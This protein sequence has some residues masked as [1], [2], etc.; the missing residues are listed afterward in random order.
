MSVYTKR[1]VCGSCLGIN[2]IPV[3]NLDSV[4]LA[5]DFPSKKELK[6]EKLY[7]LKIKFCVDCFLLQ[8]DSIVDS[9]F[10]FK[11]YRYL[12]SIGLT[13]HFTNV[14]E[15]YRDKFNLNEKSNVLD[16]G[17]NDGVLVKPLQDLS[18]NTSGIDPSIN[19]T[20]IARKNGCK[21]IITDF[22]SA[23]NAVKYFT[24]ESFDLI[25][26]NNCFA[27]I[28][29]IHT[30]ISGVKK[31][32]KPDGVFVIEVH[33]V[34]NLIK[35]LQYDN[36]YHE[37]IYYYSL[38]SLKN[39]LEDHDMYIVDYDEIPVHAGSIRVYFKN[40][41]SKDTKSPEKVLKKLDQEESS[42]LCNL[43]FYQ[44]FS[45]TVQNHLENTKQ[46][47]LELST[48]HKIIGYGASGRANMLSHLLG[49]STDIIEYIVDESP[50][51][52]NRYL[53]KTHIPIYDK[54]HLDDDP[55]KPEYIFIFAWNF[56]K[57]IIDKLQDLDCSFIIPMPEPHIVKKSEDLMNL[58]L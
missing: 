58:T 36:I 55:E 19:V 35:N 4:P 47:L 51:R 57:M 23:E 13:K 10:L 12:S 54:K 1:S 43:E 2:L 5:G 25:T 20:D 48:S 16:I 27:H 38:N 24:P 28:A 29:N 45:N 3:L 31:L 53:A 6:S 44:N 34:Y 22:F 11:D 14:A 17:C 46:L 39:L 37:H 40:K 9:G 30:I 33:Y 26:C 32:L 18:I 49:L 41:L 7:P 50:E 56:A 52:Y 21:N 42:G 15:M 8:T